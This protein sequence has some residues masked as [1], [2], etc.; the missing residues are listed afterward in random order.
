M[1]QNGHRPRNALGIKNF[2][3][4]FGLLTNS[5]RL[6]FMIFMLNFGP[7][8]LIRFSIFA[9]EHV[10]SRIAKLAQFT[11]VVLLRALG[12]LFPS[13]FFP[14]GLSRDR[15]RS[16]F[17]I[18]IAKIN[19]SAK[20]LFPLFASATVKVAFIDVIGLRNNAKLICKR[21]ATCFCILIV[22]RFCAF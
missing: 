22:S 10:K 6:I 8:Q 17:A 21:F 19:D 13:V 18:L 12:R 15:D 20:A 3:F 16:R 1:P 7:K 14:T 2:N 5:P 4:I 9:F 11:Y